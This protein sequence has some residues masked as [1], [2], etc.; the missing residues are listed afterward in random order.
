MADILLMSLFCCLGRVVRK[1]VSVN[2]GLKVNRTINFSSIKM[3]FTAYDL[4]GP[5]LVKLRAE[6]Q[7]VETQNLIERLQDSNQNSR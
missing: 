1:P 4:C 6:G 2:P 7:T 3:F 5:S